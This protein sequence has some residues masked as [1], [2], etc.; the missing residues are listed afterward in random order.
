MNARNAS[1]SDD[2]FAAK[3]ETLM[4]PPQDASPEPGCAA[5]QPGEDGGFRTPRAGVPGEFNSLGSAFGLA[6]AESETDPEDASSSPA[7]MRSSVRHPYL[8]HIQVAR[9]DNGDP[10]PAADEFQEVLCEDL[11]T[12]GAAVFLKDRPDSEMFIVGLGEPPNRT[13]LLARVA[14]VEPVFR[15]GCQFLRRLQVDPTTGAWVGLPGDNRSEEGS[16]PRGE[17]NT[18]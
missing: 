8:H 5:A 14:H 12:G 3:L 17:A 7:E 6:P 11:S 9:L 1:T 15:V 13:Y 16:L 10:P 2:A 4:N 18:H